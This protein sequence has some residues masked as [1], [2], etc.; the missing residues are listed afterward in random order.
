MSK[1]RIFS[2]TSYFIED[3]KLSNGNSIL[4][5]A[6]GQTVEASPAA[7]IEAFVSGD[8]YSKTESIN[9]TDLNTLIMQSKGIVMTINYDKVSVEKSNKQYELDLQEQAEKVQ[10][11]LI[12]KGMPAVIEI[13]KNPVTKV[14]QGENRTIRGYHNSDKL[15]SNGYLDFI[16]MEEDKTGKRYMKKQVNTEPCWAIIR[17]TKYIVK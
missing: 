17:G 9:K 1:E 10:K 4:V 5:N 12:A 8:E 11:A 14:T 2:L 13:L 7:L 6:K 16:D 15:N 3:K